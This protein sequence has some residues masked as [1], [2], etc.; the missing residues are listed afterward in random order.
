MQF[1]TK[2]L[3]GKS[4]QQYTQRE[5]LPPFSQVSAFRYGSMEELEKV[6]AHKSIRIHLHLLG[7]SLSASVLRLWRRSGRIFQSFPSRL[8]EIDWFG[9]IM[10]QPHKGLRL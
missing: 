4:I 1:N 3:H 5:I 8:T 2:L 9:W 7:M 6:F 10:G